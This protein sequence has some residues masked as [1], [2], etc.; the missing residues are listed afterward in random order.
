MSI[1]FPS[2]RHL[3]HPPSFLFPS[4]FLWNCQ[5]QVQGSMIKE[6][7]SIQEEYRKPNA[8]VIF[9]LYLCVG[10]RGKYVYD[11]KKAITW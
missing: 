2:L 8:L 3:T 9:I 11:I 4:N 5:C 7:P 10:Y 6:L 1:T